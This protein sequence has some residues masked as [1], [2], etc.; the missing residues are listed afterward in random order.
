MEEVILPWGDANTDCLV[1]RLLQRPSDRQHK[2]IKFYLRPLGFCLSCRYRW[3]IANW[4]LY[5]RL[6]T[7]FECNNC[8]DHPRQPNILG[9]SAKKQQRLL[10]N[11]ERLH[12]Q[13]KDK[14]LWEP[15][16]P[17][18]TKVC[19]N[20]SLGD[21]GSGPDIKRNKQTMNFTLEETLS[22]N[23][24]WKSLSDDDDLLSLLN[25]WR[26]HIAVFWGS[27]HGHLWK[28][29]KLRYMIQLDKRF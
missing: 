3:E 12:T 5:D 29:Q 25:Q 9:V 21:N 16:I 6:K 1:P 8:F 23:D 26:G 24:A 4:V 7:L 22:R 11:Q 15:T 10:M 19:A 17:V 18:P 28:G 14:A 13:M 2:K 20:T 27:L